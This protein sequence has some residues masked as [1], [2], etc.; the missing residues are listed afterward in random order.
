MESYKRAITAKPKFDSCGNRCNR[1]ND[2]PSS[3]SSKQTTF[4]DAA[5]CTND[6]PLGLKSAPMSHNSS[7]FYHTSMY[8]TQFQHPALTFPFKE[9]SR[10]QPIKSDHHSRHHPFGEKGLKRS[11]DQYGN[12]MLY[13]APVLNKDTYCQLARRFN[14]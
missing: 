3:V 10:R 13:V 11:Y 5:V 12:R 1:T 7:S 8:T 4:A 14:Y 2:E 9:D 6:V